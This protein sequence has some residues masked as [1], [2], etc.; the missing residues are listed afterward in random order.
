MNKPIEEQ[1]SQ[2]IKSKRFLEELIITNSNFLSGSGI[3]DTGLITEP[4][5]K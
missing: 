4:A 2:K 1:M 5:E 3:S